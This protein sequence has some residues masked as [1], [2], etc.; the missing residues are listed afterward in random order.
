MNKEC[1]G[2]FIKFEWGSF[3]SVSAFSFCFLFL[4]EGSDGCFGFSFRVASEY[5]EGCLV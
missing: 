1:D 3:I 5:V 2:H 4:S